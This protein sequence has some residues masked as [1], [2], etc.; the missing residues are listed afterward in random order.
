MSLIPQSSVIDPVLE[1][2]KYLIEVVN[3]F[4]DS[5]NFMF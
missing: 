2:N 1:L 5:E 3:K 4:P